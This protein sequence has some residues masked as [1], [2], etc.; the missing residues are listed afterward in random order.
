[1]CLTIDCVNDNEI[2]F[3]DTRGI[4]SLK[5]RQEAVYVQEIPG[6]VGGGE[7]SGL[8]PVIPYDRKKPYNRHTVG[9]LLFA[10]SARE[11]T[12]E[13]KFPPSRFF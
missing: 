7:G 8:Y 3:R 4:C 10:P 2:S 6:R 9:V 12:S 1:M 11:I 13:G 5:E